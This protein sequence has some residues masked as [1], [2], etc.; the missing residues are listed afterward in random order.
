MPVHRHSG[1][2]RLNRRLRPPSKKRQNKIRWRRLKSSLMRTRGLE[3]LKQFLRKHLDYYNHYQKDFEQD[4]AEILQD[5]LAEDQSED[6]AQALA[7]KCARDEPDADDKV[8]QISPVSIWTWAKSW[9][10]RGLAK[11]NSSHKIICSANRAPL[12]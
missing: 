7:H 4:L 5:N 6:D 2:L 10:M 8:N 12:S 9:N 11:R 1:G 3:A